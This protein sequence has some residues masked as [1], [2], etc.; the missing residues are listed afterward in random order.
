MAALALAFSLEVAAANSDRSLS[1]CNT[2]TRE[3]LD[4][5]YFRNGS[6]DERA[7]RK[8]NWFLRDWRR[9]EATKMDPL[10][11]DLVHEV[12]GRSGASAC[13]YVHSGYRSKVTNEGLRKRSSGV[14]RNSQHIQG[15]AMDFRIPGIDTSRLR[16]IAMKLQVGGVGYYPRSASPFVHLDVSRV[17]HWPRMSSKQ[18]AKLFPDGKTIHVPSNGRPLEGYKAAMAELDKV[19]RAARINGTEAPAKSVGSGKNLFA[20]IFSGG[21]SSK[22]D[23]EDQV[24]SSA[25]FASNTQAEKRSPDSSALVLVLA[26]PHPKPDREPPISVATAYAP[27]SSVV[28][29][30]SSGA[31]PFEALLGTSSA[32]RLISGSEILSAS[33]EFFDSSEFKEMDNLLVV[34]ALTNIRGASTN[35]LGVDFLE[36]IAVNGIPDL[37]SVIFTPRTADSWI[38]PLAAPS[39]ISPVELAKARLRKKLL[40]R[41]YGIQPYAFESWVASQGNIGYD[42]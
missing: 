5:T 3:S 34:T 9:S 12:Y 19:P 42:P 13:I 20:R 8:L 33:G 11:F 18:L 31:S 22:P 29:K 14:A 25:S 39:G 24:R 15:K 30:A 6:Y 10:L 21:R 23:A 1:L 26:T 37:T 2:N 41:E 4:I 36:D 17:R 35:P 16:E 38:P 32:D 7:L 28:D 40:D 27:A